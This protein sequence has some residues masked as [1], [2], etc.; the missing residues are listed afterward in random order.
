MIAQIPQIIFACGKYF[1]V[2]EFEWSLFIRIVRIS[3]FRR[4]KIYGI[5]AII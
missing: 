4:K 1:G 2:H 3:F 5:C